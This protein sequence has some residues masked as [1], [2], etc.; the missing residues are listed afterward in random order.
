MITQTSKKPRKIELKYRKKFLLE[1]SLKQERQNPILY[2]QGFAIKKILLNAITRSKFYTKITSFSDFDMTLFQS[3]EYFMTHFSISVKEWSKIIL[4]I[5][6]DP[7]MI[8]E[9]SNCRE[10]L[11]SRE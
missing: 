4:E 7:L 6:A 11:K 5:K 3:I 8:D 9:F 2:P 10:T 1:P